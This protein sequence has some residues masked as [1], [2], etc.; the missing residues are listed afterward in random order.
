LQV[1]RARRIINGTDQAAR[2][3][4]YAKRIETMLVASV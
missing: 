2:I 1:P 3:A 4:R